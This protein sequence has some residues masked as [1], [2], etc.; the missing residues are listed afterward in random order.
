MPQLWIMTQAYLI[1]RGLRGLR[2]ICAEAG[3][4]NGDE[5]KQ[6]RKLALFRVESGTYTGFI[7]DDWAWSINWS[8]FSIF[9]RAVEGSIWR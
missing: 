9:L 7:I 2:R 5:A 4:G 3:K 6:R 8:S 1:K